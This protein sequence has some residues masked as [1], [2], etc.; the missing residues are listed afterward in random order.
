[1]IKANNEQP[2]DNRFPYIR[3]GDTFFKTVTTI[4]K[5]GNEVIRLSKRS[6]QTFVDDFDKEMI[7]RVPKYDDFCNIPSHTSFFQEIDSCFNIYNRIEHEQKE[8]KF[9]TIEKFLKHIFGEH[10]EM[11]Y[12]YF[13]ILWFEPLQSLPILCLVSEENETGKTTFG[14]FIGAVFG[15]NFVSIGQ[16]ELTTE[17]NSSYASKLVAMVDESWIDYKVIDKLKYMS[18]NSTIQLRQMHRDHSSIG[19]F[20]K[21]ILC[22]NRTKEFIKAND[23]DERYW[24]RKITKFKAFDPKFLD[25]LKLEIPYFL[26][27]I[28][29]RELSTKRESRNHFSAM[30]IRTEAFDDVVKHT[31]DVKLKEIAF[32]LLEYMESKEVIQLNGTPSHIKQNLFDRMSH[33]T[34]IMI[35]NFLKDELKLNHSGIPSWYTFEGET[36]QRQGTFYTVSAEIL[37]EYL[38]IEKV[39]YTI[40]DKLDLSP[41]NGKLLF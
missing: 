28:S 6:R 19:F 32:I 23:N 20:C 1:M 35:R 26:Y 33:I 7:K 10:L 34:T 12:D 40:E 14:N 4:D 24:I 18:T 8:G 13:Q 15:A 16:N 11:G 38:G 25:K 9:T 22:S 17:F 5:N 27:F 31:I 36:Q 30:S 2:K 37:R 29:N 3:I 21:F 41:N 39:N